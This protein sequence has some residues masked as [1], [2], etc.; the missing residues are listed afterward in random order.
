MPVAEQAVAAVAEQVVAAVANSWA[1]AN[2]S[3]AEATASHWQQS[4]SYV[5]A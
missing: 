2:S 5:D 4:W 3:A 1:V